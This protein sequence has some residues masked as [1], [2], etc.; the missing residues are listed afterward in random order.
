MMPP[1]YPVEQVGSDVSGRVDLALLRF[2][3]AWRAGAR[4]AI[5]DYLPPEPEARREALVELA[6][7]EL[8]CRL[9]AGEEARVEQYL[10]RY[11]EIAADQDAVLD[12]LATE[13]EQR[14]RRAGPTFEE[15]LTRFPQYRDELLAAEPARP[16]WG[17]RQSQIQNPKSE[18]SNPK[19]EGRVSD[20]GFEIS[21]FSHSPRLGK[22]E[23]GDLLGTG[24][25]GTVYKAWDT[26]LRRTVALKLPRA[27]SHAPPEDVE[28]L[29]KEARSAAALQHPSI[30]ALYEAGQADGTSYLASEFIAGPTLADRCGQGSLPPREAA[31]LI[32]G[33]AEALHYAH[34]QGVIHR[35][36][37][38]SN[39][40]LDCEGRPHLADFGLARRVMS[41]SLAT[42]QGQILGTPAYMSPE[43]ARGEREKIDGRSDVYSLGVVLYELLAGV[44]PF[45]GDIHLVL[46]QVLED[47]PMPPRRM[48]AGIPRDLENICLR[49]TSKEPGRRYPT[50]A[51]LAEDLR[52]FLDG[53]PVRARPISAAARGWRWCRRRPLAAGLAAL[54]ALALIVGSMVSTI[55]WQRAELESKRL[56][57]QRDRNELQLAE[58]A[59]LRLHLAAQ[60]RAIAETELKAPFWVRTKL[61]Q[62]SLQHARE[63][64]QSVRQTPLDKSRPREGL[65]SLR[66]TPLDESNIRWLV[67]K[68]QLEIARAETLM[69]ALGNDELGEH[70]KPGYQVYAQLPRGGKAQAYQEPARRWTDMLAQ[71]SDTPES[72]IVRVKCFLLAAQ[73]E[74]NVEDAIQHLKQA[75]DIAETLEL[76]HKSTFPLLARSYLMLGEAQ[77]WVGRLDE[78][79]ATLR[80]ACDWPKEHPLLTTGPDGIFR[81]DQRIDCSLSLAEL[82]VEMNHPE[83]ARPFV[84]LAKALLSPVPP[85]PPHLD[86]ELRREA[87][88]LMT[89]VDR[90]EYGK[91]YWK[92]P[93]LYVL[94]NHW[95]VNSNASASLKEQWDRFHSRLGNVQCSLGEAP[96]N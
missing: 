50:A 96:K 61:L 58:A 94:F 14:Q 49:A 72:R 27:G 51:A 34:L 66:Q 42:C 76:E 32:A 26:E 23:V 46:R 69:L 52:R 33:V 53:H 90:G 11:P 71:M 24:S 15:Y 21:G 39:I 80:K 41:E 22:Y 35:D 30:V 19:S 54:L 45:R 28:R 44:V 7:T 10:G 68:Y 29:L 88:A 91:A 25:F 47:E 55:L 74:F 40:L 83:Q 87:K 1:A 38:P 13:F 81:E 92:L 85:S 70:W 3:E 4:P 79:V 67:G 31:G 37:K 60:L 5:E 57:R 20:F 77:H 36:I 65:Q 8:E 78:A 59:G 64:L 62:A 18:I 17:R 89:A 63:G 48:I 84:R 12:L 16:P 73:S 82:Y 2:E 9:R 6:H 43:Q 75:R 86:A 56:E 93:D 95:R